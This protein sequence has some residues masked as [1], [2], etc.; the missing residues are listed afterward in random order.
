MQSRQETSRHTRCLYTVTAS[1]TGMTCCVIVQQH[2]ADRRA[3]RRNS[4]NK[5]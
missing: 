5:Q 2:P 1:T 4:Q 3:V